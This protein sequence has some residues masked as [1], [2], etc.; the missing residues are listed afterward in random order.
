VNTND[1]LGANLAN[2]FLIKKTVAYATVSDCCIGFFNRRGLVFYGLALSLFLTACSTAPQAP[3]GAFAYPNA[4]TSSRVS[5]EQASDITIYAVGLVGTPYRFGGN[6]PD[7]GFDC[8]GLIG[9]VYQS[10]AEVAPPRT[11][12][13]LQS[14]G[15]A[16]ANDSV[17]SGD[18]VLFAQSDVATHAGIYVGDGRFVHAPSAGGEVRLDRLNSKYWST[19]RVSFRR[20]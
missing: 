13:R 8:S 9:H 2:Q 19:Q 7:T 18:L 6:T 1:F 10:R 3:H 12:S 15:Q 14:W 5:S 17:R 16:V 4:Q 11:V 20:P